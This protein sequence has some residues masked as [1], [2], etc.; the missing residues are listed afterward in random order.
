[1]LLVS[2]KESLQFW[3]KSFPDCLTNKWDNVCMTA[4]IE[5]KFSLEHQGNHKPLGG[6]LKPND[7]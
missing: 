5:N 2:E 3:E 1:M 6:L 7:I 4:I